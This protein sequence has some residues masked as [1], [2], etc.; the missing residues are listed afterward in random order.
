MARV[1]KLLLK[2]IKICYFQF[3]L[4][5]LTKNVAPFQIWHNISGAL[6]G[7]VGFAQVYCNIL[8]ASDVNGSSLTL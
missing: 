4:R 3:L 2:E 7:N 6:G 5:I 1:N 8:V